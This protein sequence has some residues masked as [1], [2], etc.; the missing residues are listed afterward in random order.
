MAGK[1]GGIGDEGDESGR[2]D[3]DS[4]ALITI[5]PCGVQKS[6]LVLLPGLQ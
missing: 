1:R 5:I 3:G 2:L 6:S 4:S